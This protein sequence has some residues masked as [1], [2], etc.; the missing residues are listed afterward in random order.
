MLMAVVSL[1]L[2]A[3]INA[4]RLLRL[5]SPAIAVADMVCGKLVTLSLF[6]ATKGN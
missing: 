3:C 1:P 5:P 4:Y 2:S 6:Q